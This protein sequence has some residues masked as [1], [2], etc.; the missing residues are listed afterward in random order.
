MKYT[1]KLHNETHKGLLQATC[2]PQVCETDLMI[3]ILS[4]CGLNIGSGPK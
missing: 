4:K 2:E 1:F 3:E